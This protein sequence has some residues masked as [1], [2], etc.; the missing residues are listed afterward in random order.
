MHFLLLLHNKTQRIVEHFECEAAAV[1]DIGFAFGVRKVTS[2][3]A[4]GE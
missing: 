4:A 2:N 1:G 3:M